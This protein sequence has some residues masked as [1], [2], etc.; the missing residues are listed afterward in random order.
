MT[1]VKTM[2][3]AGRVMPSDVLIG[4][5]AQVAIFDMSSSKYY[6]MPRDK[7]TLD[8]L[9]AFPDFS[10]LNLASQTPSV[11]SVLEPHSIEGQPG[12]SFALAA[13]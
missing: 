12:F 5:L 1:E 8:E 13:R 3:R 11:I 4:L 10:S 2:S 6:I 7:N 9:H